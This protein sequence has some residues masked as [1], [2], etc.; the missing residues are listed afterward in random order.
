MISLFRKIRQTLLQQNRVTR[1]LA[2]ALGEIFLVVVGILI[3]LQLNIVKEDSDHKKATNQLLIGIQSDLQ[4]EVERID[5][6]ISYYSHI[7]DGIQQIILTHQGKANPSNEEL[8]QYFLNAFEFRKF[9]KFNTNYQTVYGS[10]LLQ[11]IDDKEV[12][13]EIITYYSKQFLEWSLEIYQEQAGAFDFKNSPQFDPLDKLRKTE[14]YKSIPNYQLEVNQTYSTDFYEFIQDPQVLN[15]LVDL[16][17]QSEL[18]YTNLNSYR[19]TNRALFDQIT[20]YL[21]P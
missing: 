11:E 10:G 19:E 5:F 20:N 13:E 4:L 8:G 15:Y 16:L 1:Y 9:S 18:V 17:D 14:P 6:L 12:S 2:Y 7:T 21:K 3:A